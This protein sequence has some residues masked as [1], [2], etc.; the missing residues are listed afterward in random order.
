M[1]GIQPIASFSQ[2]E[3][4]NEDMGK[5]CEDRSTNELSGIPTIL[6]LLLFGMAVAPLA[7]DLAGDFGTKSLD[8]LVIEGS[9]MLLFLVGL[10]LLL[11]QWVIERQQRIHAIRELRAVSAQGEQWHTEAR[12]WRTQASTLIQGLGEA[13]EAQFTEWGLT[14]AEREVASS[15][16][17]G[18]TQKEIAAL[19]SRSEHTVRQQANS[20]YRKG[21]LAGRRELASFFLVNLLPVSP[22][23]SPERRNADRGF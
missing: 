23:L 4:A 15:L 20:V 22:P 9:A 2:I 10:A 13:I 1:S 17:K 11:R 3:G 19:R 5:T 18:L 14:E 12:K 16:L 6:P 7:F 8:H 21:G